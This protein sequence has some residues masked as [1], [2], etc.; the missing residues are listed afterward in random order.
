MK[1]VNIAM[2]DSFMKIFGYKRVKPTD[3]ELRIDRH[4]QVDKCRKELES[5]GDKY[6]I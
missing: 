1:K 3:K 4:K 5:F 2:V 6:D